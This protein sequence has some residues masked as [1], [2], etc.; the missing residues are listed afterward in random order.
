MKK[1]LDF[2]NGDTAF[3]CLIHT[4][5]NHGLTQTAVTNGVNHVGDLKKKNKKRLQIGRQLHAAII[6]KIC[7]NDVFVWTSLV[8]MYTKYGKIK[9]S[10]MVFDGIRMRN[11]VTWT[12][13][14]SGYA[15]NGLGEEAVNLFRVMKRRNISANKLTMVSILRACGR[16]RAYQQERNCMHK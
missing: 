10:R 3:H 8:D 4:L 5:L 12:S 14:I 1:P 6:K 7:R 11:M 16:I 15:W 13:I 2:Y 9:N